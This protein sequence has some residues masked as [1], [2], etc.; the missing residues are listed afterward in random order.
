MSETGNTKILYDVKKFLD[1]DPEEEDTFFDTIIIGNINTCIA[2]LAHQGGLKNVGDFS[3]V[4]GD[5]TWD[6]YLGESELYLLAFVKAYVQIGTKLTFDPPQS[7]S[8]CSALEEKY[9]K[10]LFNIQTQIELHNIESEDQ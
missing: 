6:D 9:K 10:T 7:S 4:T 1:R 2:E 5:E 8:L 3:V